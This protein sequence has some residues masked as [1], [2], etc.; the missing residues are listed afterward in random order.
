MDIKVRGK[1][2]YKPLKVKNIWPMLKE[3]RIRSQSEQKDEENVQ[4]R[5]DFNAFSE[6]LTYKGYMDE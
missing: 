3:I 1:Y 4:N 5:V 6:E 2:E